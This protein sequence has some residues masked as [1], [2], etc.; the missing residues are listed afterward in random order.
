[1]NDYSRQKQ[2]SAQG[3]EQ[4]RPALPEIQVFNPSLPAADISPIRYTDI[5]TR[6]VYTAP[7]DGIPARNP[8]N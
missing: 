7:A 3:H 2:A 8:D 5:R 6:I 4:L 1:M